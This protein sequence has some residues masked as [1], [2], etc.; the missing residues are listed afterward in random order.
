M[1]HHHFSQE[2]YFP[3]ELDNKHIYDMPGGDVLWRKPAQDK[4]EPVV[5]EGL[6]DEVTFKQ[7]LKEVSR[8]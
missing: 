2:T 7:R 5:R 4:I 1:T 6:S 8:F 3:L